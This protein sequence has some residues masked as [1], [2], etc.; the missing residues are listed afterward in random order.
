MSFPSLSQRS[1]SLS[2]VIFTVLGCDCCHDLLDLFDDLGVSLIDQ[3]LLTLADSVLVQV[4]L[5][6]R[7]VL[8]GAVARVRRGCVLLLVPSG[9][10][11]LVNC[12]DLGG[13]V[14]GYGGLDDKEWAHKKIANSL[15]TR[16]TLSKI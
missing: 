4:F 7:V 1:G 8:R 3:V 2:A 15:V 14:P 5:A 9:L 16:L 13:L 6:G 12:D 10:G 11:V